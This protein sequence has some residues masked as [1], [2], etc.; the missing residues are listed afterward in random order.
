MKESASYTFSTNRQ[1]SY[2]CPKF[3]VLSLSLAYRRKSTC[4]EREKVSLINENQISKSH[5]LADSYA[6]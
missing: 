2:S 5:K 6:G 3:G 4:L 1:F